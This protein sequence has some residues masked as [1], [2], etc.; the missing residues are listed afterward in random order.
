MELT[1][2]NYQSEIVNLFILSNIIKKGKSNEINR[3]DLEK[4]RVLKLI[5]LMINRL[6]EK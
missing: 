4:R 6:V 2:D 3:I 5:F 1:I